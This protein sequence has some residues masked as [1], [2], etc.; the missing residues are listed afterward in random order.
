MKI[1]IRSPNWMGDAVMSL[2]SIA[3]LKEEMPDSRI[4]VLAKNDIKDIFLNNPAVDEIISFNKPKKELTEEIKKANF[5]I[6]ILFTNSFSS[7]F[8]F[9]RTGVKKRVGYKTDL[10]TFLL[11]DG[12]PLPPNLNKTHQKDYY[13]N[14]IN[15]LIGKEGAPKIPH[16]PLSK[17]EI[18]R[19][20]TILEKACIEKIAGIAPGAGYGPAKMWQAEKFKAL[21][22]R[23]IKENNVKVFIFGGTK[24]KELGKIIQ[25]K[26]PDIFN[27]C[28]KTTTRELLALIKKC[29]IFITN[30]TGP[31]HAAYALGVPVVAIF[32]PT[33]PGRTAPLGNSIVIKKKVECSP[34]KH[35]I[36]PKKN[37]ECMEKISVEEVYETVKK[38]LK[39]TEDLRPKTED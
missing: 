5:D 3:Y 18:K 4:T 32:G 34:C 6:G 39:Q 31:M 28:G 16:I 23:L 21:A 2:P 19:A 17:E 26:N 1:I 25:D 8:L 9:F 27:F 14:I 12:I 24:E 37:H 38:L 35:R 33:I 22:E 7:A 11:T 10:R 20:D 15:H 36:C 13:L 29:N 30:D